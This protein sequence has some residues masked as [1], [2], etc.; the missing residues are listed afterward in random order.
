MAG[1]LLLDPVESGSKS[2]TPATSPLTEVSVDKVKKETK[3][4]VEEFIVN[5]DFKVL[6]LVL[7]ISFKFI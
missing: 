2:S 7:I 3:L 5:N 6:L 1:V 4:T